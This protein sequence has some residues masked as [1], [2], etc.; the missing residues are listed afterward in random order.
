MGSSCCS[1]TTCCSTYIIIIGAIGIIIY[2]LVI[3]SG[4]GYSHHDDKNMKDIIEYNIG[5]YTI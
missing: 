4:S 1:M 3:L 5:I 2:D